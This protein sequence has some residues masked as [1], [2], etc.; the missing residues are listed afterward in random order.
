MEPES[1]IHHASM[2]WSPYQCTLKR[3]VERSGSVANR[4]VLSEISEVLASH[5]DGE[6]AELT[7]D[8]RR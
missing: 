4:V 8:L 3:R 6:V 2:N 7:G 1:G 5:V